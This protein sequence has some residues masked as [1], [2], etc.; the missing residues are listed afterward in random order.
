[1]C[2]TDICQSNFGSNYFTF[3]ENTRRIAIARDFWVFA[4]LWLGLTL[5]TAAVY[6]YTYVRKRKP[7]AT[8]EEAAERQKVPSGFST[9]SKASGRGRK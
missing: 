6:V 3:N 9:E 2:T 8:S 7:Q 4:L 5:L 1:V